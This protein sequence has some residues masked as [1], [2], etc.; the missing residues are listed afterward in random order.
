MPNKFLNSIPTPSQWRQF[1]FKSPWW[2]PQNFFCSEDAD[3]RSTCCTPSP[4][5]MPASRSHGPKG[6]S[7]IWKEKKHP[8]FAP[9]FPV[10][11]A[12]TAVSG[13]LLTKTP[14]TRFSCF[15]NSLPTFL[16]TG[17]VM[18]LSGL[19]LSF[20]FWRISFWWGYSLLLSHMLLQWKSLELDSM[21]TT[22][23]MLLLQVPLSKLL[24][25]M[26]SV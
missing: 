20:C 5:A 8:R 21:L 15:S 3:T 7:H 19:A 17:L 18:R 12:T 26:Q 16:L 22:M 10:R 13:E 23:K 4:Q 11:F 24:S 9:Q 25:K 6:F 1:F 2:R 14:Y